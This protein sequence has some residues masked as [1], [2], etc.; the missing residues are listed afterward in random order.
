[1]L[2]ALPFPVLRYRAPQ[3]KPEALSLWVLLS[4]VLALLFSP[5]KDG[6]KRMWPGANTLSFQCGGSGLLCLAL[7]T[8]EPLPP[9]PARMTGPC[10]AVGSGA[11]WALWALGLSGVPPLAYGWFFLK[12]WTR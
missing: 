6:W 2:R 10:G 1:M 12:G 9:L 5:Y 4:G 7:P 3:S 11:L 8:C